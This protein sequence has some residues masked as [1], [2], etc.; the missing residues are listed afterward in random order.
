MH[1]VHQYQEPC[2]ANQG[3][4]APPVPSSK[5]HLSSVIVD[6]CPV[7]CVCVDSAQAQCVCGEKMSLCS[8]VTQMLKQLIQNAS[9]T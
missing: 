3:F 7:L 4:A 8:H 9:F 2:E 5:E 6:C 1:T